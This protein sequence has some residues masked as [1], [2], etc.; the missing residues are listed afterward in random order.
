[1]SGHRPAVQ[2]ASCCATRPTGS[3][4]AAVL[5]ATLLLQQGIQAAARQAR[6]RIPL[7]HQW[8]GTCALCV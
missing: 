8:R 1:M 2:T 5:A 3:A 7:D 6:G 4:D